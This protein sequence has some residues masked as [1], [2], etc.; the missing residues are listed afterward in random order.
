MFSE[1]RER[2]GSCATSSQITVAVGD[3]EVSADG[4]NVAFDP[5]ASQLLMVAAG[6]ALDAERTT[7]RAGDLLEALIS[8]EALGSVLA[9]LGVDVDG[10]RERLP[11]AG[12]SEPEAPELP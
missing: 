8:D 10:V 3:T 7:V 12:W 6:R 1:G 4:V 5:R 11:Y 9:S 2:P